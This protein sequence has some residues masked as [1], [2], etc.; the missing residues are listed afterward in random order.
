MTMKIFKFCKSYLSL[1]KKMLLLF[2]GLSFGGCLISIVSPYILGDFIDT[3]I[4]GT[5]KQRIINFCIIFGG[6]NAIKIFRD[7]V[8][9]ILYTKMQIEMGYKLNVD[10]LKHLQN[11]S[12]SYLNN[13]DEAYMNQ[14]ING[15]CYALITFCL[16]T[17]RDSITNITMFVFPFIIML[18]LNR[19]ILLLLVCFIVAYILIYMLMKKKIY[20]AGFKYR[21]SLAVLFSSLF[22][23]I[24]H[25]FQIKVDSIQA[26]FV[27]RTNGAFSQ[28]KDTAIKSQRLNY[29]YSS[30]DSI[31]VTFANIVLFVVGGI[32]V[33]NGSFTVGMFT[34]FSSYFRTML[35]SCSYFFGLAATYQNSVVSFNRIKDIL[36]TVKE[37]NGDIR[38]SEINTIEVENLSFSYAFYERNHNNSNDAL[39]IKKKNDTL[40]V[41]ESASYKFSRGSL[42]AIVGENGTGK[43][44]FAKLIIGL[45]IDEKKG[46]I[47]YNDVPIN[48]IDLAHARRM[49]IGYAEQ[50]P[51][52][53][54]DN[55]YYNLTYEDIQEVIDKSEDELE[56]EKL[57]KIRQLGGMLNLGEL[58]DNKTLTF[59]INEN[60]TNLSGGEKQKIAILKVLYKNPDVMIF[61]EPTSALDKDTKERFIRYLQNIKHNKIIIVVTHDD[62]LVSCC[63]Q[64]V[65]MSIL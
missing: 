18:Y 50:N 48:S 16:T 21:E 5:T 52:L 51:T 31:V 6:L 25:I 47:Y 12:I 28:Y 11:L 32:L 15:D 49:L 20:D 29:L 36:S 58:F 40:N 30:L 61:D 22:E 34:I 38:V 23:Q 1:K 26:E 64:I 53:I 43:T 63:D 10:V 24:R 44:T 42:Y 9:W 37:S 4:T 62:E 60:A 35:S 14:K 17:L 55:I 46:N 2:I 13:Q 33:I 56:N 19:N 7:Y 8:T 3:L 59:R 57:I 41:I 65:D 54:Q 39:P 27:K 45:Y